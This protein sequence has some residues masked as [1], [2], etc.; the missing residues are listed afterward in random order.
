MNYSCHAWISHITHIYALV[1]LHDAPLHRAARHTYGVATISRLLKI[2]G[3]FCKRA[4]QKRL[5]SAKETYN[6]KE[7]TSRG[8]PIWIS[9]VTY[10]W[11]ND[12][13]RQVVMSSVNGSCHVWMSHATFEWVMSHMNESLIHMRLM[14]SDSALKRHSFI[15]E[16]NRHSFI[17]HVNA[18]D[19]HSYVMWMQ[20]TL[21]HMSCE[22][23]RHLFICHVNATDTHS[24]VMWMQ[25]TLI[26]MSMKQALNHMWMKE[27]LIHTSFMQSDALTHTWIRS[28]HM[29]MSHV[30]CDWVMSHVNEHITYERVMSHMCI[31]HFTHVHKSFHTYECIM[32]HM[33]H[34]THEPGREGGDAWGQEQDPTW[35]QATALELAP[36]SGS[37]S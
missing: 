25:Q 33:S 31:S 8:H 7:P 29:W 22:C 12:V 21:I 16:C 26:H 28:C 20:Q 27:A 14:Q 6:F 35:R 2:T 24:Y 34:F 10:T 4:L 17:C 30:T 19:T 13:I 23:N 3:L 11:R 18:T 37:N 9:R 5:Y 36:K 1:S 15:C 32:S